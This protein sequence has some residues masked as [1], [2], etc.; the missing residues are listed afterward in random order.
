M[1]LASSP[2]PLSSLIPARTKYTSVGNFWLEARIIRCSEIKIYCL[3]SEPG[4]AEQAKCSSVSV[5]PSISLTLA[6]P[7]CACIHMC[8]WLYNDFEN[9]NEFYY[10]EV[11]WIF[12]K[13]MLE[14]VYKLPWKQTKFHDICLVFAFTY[15]Q[16]TSFLTC[17]VWHKTLVLR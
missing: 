5:C 4:I 11:L 7:P 3:C 9:S 15:A 14:V 16:E 12:P 8:A 17:Y 10:L 6:I 13:S 1:S 2:F